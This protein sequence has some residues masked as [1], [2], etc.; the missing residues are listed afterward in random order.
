MPFFAPPAI[1]NTMKNLVEA[2]TVLARKQREM[3][4]EANDILDEEEGLNDHI[5]AYVNMTNEELNKEVKRMANATKLLRNVIN[6]RHI[7]RFYK[8]SHFVH[9]NLHKI[10][11][12]VEPIASEPV[13]LTELANKKRRITKVLEDINI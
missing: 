4:D 6:E 13:T 10:K 1:D 8:V 7:N 12:T 5:S 9:E 11:N 2:D 3:V